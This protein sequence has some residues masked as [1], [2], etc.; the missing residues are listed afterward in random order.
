MKKQEKQQL[1]TCAINFS[2]FFFLVCSL[3][4]FLPAVNIKYNSY[5]SCN[6]RADVK[7][8]TEYV[9]DITYKLYFSILSL[10]NVSI[11]LTYKVP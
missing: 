1:Q 7:W 5:V 3:T 6:C 2:C 8:K 4:E 11:I 10:Q 9:V